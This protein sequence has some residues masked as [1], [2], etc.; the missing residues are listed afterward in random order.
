VLA[1]SYRT[2]TVRERHAKVEAPILLGST[3]ASSTPCLAGLLSRFSLLLIT[4]WVT[5]ENQLAE[6]GFSRL[7]CFNAGFFGTLK[8]PLIQAR[9]RGSNSVH[10]SAYTFVEKLVKTPVSS[11]C[12]MIVTNSKGT[13]VSRTSARKPAV[14]RNLLALVILPTTF[15][16]ASYGTDLLDLAPSGQLTTWTADPEGRVFTGSC[17]YDSSND[18]YEHGCLFRIDTDGSVHVVEEGIQLSNG[19]GF[20]P[21]STT[22]YY[23]DSAGSARTVTVFSAYELTCHGEASPTSRPRGLY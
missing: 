19:I 16:G 3:I 4:V 2:A 18:Q 22:M 10:K 9:P 8:S 5:P 20:S 12:T 14:Y 23:A 21:D 7:F 6:I 17:F 13:R 15:A 1:A 11:C